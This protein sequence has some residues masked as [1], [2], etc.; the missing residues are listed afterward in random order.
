MPTVRSRLIA[1]PLDQVWATLAAFDQIG[2]WA[3][4]VDHAAY[5]S[6]VTSGVGAA[7]RV[8]AGR[9][10]LLETV[11]EWAPPERLAYTLGGLPAI[12]GR[13]TNSWRL[14]PASGATQVT[15]TTTIEP[16]PRLA[17]KIVAA[18]LARVAGRASDEL[19]D[20][21]ASYHA[22]GGSATERA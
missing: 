17:S 14:E 10:T 20:G 1:A 4:N 18:V 6:S 16:G 3:N 5:T 2:R 9:V 22:A 15:L 11:V 8:Q 21:L 13:V 7:R 12:A 19:L